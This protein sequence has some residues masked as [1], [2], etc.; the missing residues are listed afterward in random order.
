MTL[1]AAWE[2]YLSAL[3]AHDFTTAVVGDLVTIVDSK[4]A[5]RRSEE[6]R[7]GRPVAEGERIITQLLPLTNGEVGD[8]LAVVKPLLSDDAEVLAYAPANTLIVTDSESNVRKVGELVEQLSV[9]APASRLKITP[10]RFAKAADV[11]AVIEALYPTTAPVAAPTRRPTKRRGKTTTSTPTLSGS[12]GQHLTKVLEDERTNSLIVLADTQGHAAVE[13]IVAELDVDG[14]GQQRL[15]VLRL[16]YALAEE[17][18]AVLVKMGSSGGQATPRPKQKGVESDLATALEGARFAAD[19]S[20]NALAVLADEEDFA[21]I[22]D[23]VEQL[24][25][26][27]RQVF[28][29][30]VFVELTN[31]DGKEFSLSGHLLGSEGQP[32]SVSSQPDVESSNSFSITSDLLS[33]LAAGVFGS[34]VE[35]LGP[36]G[37]LI[38]VPAFGVALRAMQTDD[39]VH[40]MGNPALLVLD[41]QE[42]TLSVGRKIPF[43]QSSQL[44]AFGTP[45][46]VYDRVD[47]NME[48]NLTPHINDEDLVTLDVKLDVDE[49]DGTGAGGNPET[50]GRSV[51]TNVMVEDGQ[52]IVIAGVTSVKEER[53]ESKVPF[54]GDLPL[55]GAL[56]RSRKTESRNSNLMV[57]LTPYVVDRPRDLVKI[58]RIKEAQRAEFVRRF[59]D[60]TGGAWLTE[61][62]KLL[63]DAE[64]PEDPADASGS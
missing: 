49:V 43:L 33:G 23:L 46:P 19:T 20:T 34:L 37:D 3:R 9:A 6:V 21:P 16:T 26:A 1:E 28:V 36:T 40:V 56:F 45:V 10:I 63:A 17:V 31:T 42:A 55:I 50:S 52:T 24:D 29:D 14:E 58:Q 54:F 35:V 25:T 12:P 13:E 57:F 38:S 32:V 62:E 39:D 64:D 4:D 30:A 59:Q 7:S 48:L 53:V 51:H 15:N 61:L 22:R 5:Q 41:H 11:K 47:V 18:E 44:S 2:A 60:K 8:L 27:R